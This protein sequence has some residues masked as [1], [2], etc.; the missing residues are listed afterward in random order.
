MNER[1]DQIAV[2]HARTFDWVF[3]DRN[4]GFIEWLQSDSGLFWV[5]GKPGSGKST[6][7]KCILE[8]P[9][10][11]QALQTK[12]GK[13][14]LIMP[15]FFFHDRGMN[16]TQKSIDGLFRSI[17]YQIISDIPVLA[18]PVH[19]IYKMTQ[20]LEGRCEWRT[21][22]LK[23]A[24]NS[25]VRQTKISGCIMLFV[26]ALDEF[27]GQDVE[28]ARF[29][30]EL[31]VCSQHQ[32]LRIR[33]C[34]SSR[35]HNVFQDMLGDFPGLAIH[36][37]T[38]KDIDIYTSDRLGEC[39]REGLEDLHR[40]ITSR[41][42]GVFLWV[43][44]VIEELSQALFDGEPISALLDKLSALPA[45]L[46]DFYR[47]MID[48]L[49]PD[50]QT[51]TRQMLELVLCQNEY[52]L[53]L[54]DLTVAITLPTSD[55]P[56]Q[57]CSNLD[58]HELIRNCRDMERQLRGFS[59]G[60]LQVLPDEYFKT[61]IHGHRESRKLPP[62]W[63]FEPLTPKEYAFSRRKIQFLHQTAKEFVSNPSNSDIMRGNSAKQIA[64]AGRLRFMRLYT[65]LARAGKRR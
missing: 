52:P 15:S 18:I 41:A 21:I 1:Q 55:D 63:I 61:G 16:L 37:W 46:S 60:L 11:R 12:Y 39:K 27:I 42:E 57:Y 44:L 43:R 5:R 40:E 30:Q 28:I 4:A 51:I 7:M 6:L 9:R 64:I 20:T 50:K 10:S 32:S 65:F 24:L 22:E 29:L 49:P 13:K 2:A 14:S 8:D 54:I 25:V 47:R 35:P 31:I 45:D 38:A 36:D 48:R 3:T 56:S 34:A 53:C 19:E 33:I 62:N 58:P 59:G 17:L 26:D 23:K